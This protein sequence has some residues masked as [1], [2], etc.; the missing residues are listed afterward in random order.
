MY[1]FLKEGKREW[2]KEGGREL[3]RKKERENFHLWIYSQ[4]A[5]IANGV[6]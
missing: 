6:G 4:M 2:Q 3:E 5:T 1:F